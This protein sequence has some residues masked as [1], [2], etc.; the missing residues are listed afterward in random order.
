M[1]EQSPQLKPAA[2]RY[3]DTCLRYASD[4]NSKP[5]FILA[6]EPHFIID[7]KQIV[8]S[9]V[10]QIGCQLEDASNRLQNDIDVVKA[11]LTNTPQAYRFASER[12]KNDKD[13][14]MQAVGLKGMN[15]QHSSESL[16]D[17][18]DLALLAV[19]KNAYAL[20]HVSQRLQGDKVVVL[21]AVEYFPEVI[22][23]A[24]DNLQQ[25]VGDG[26]PSEIIQKAIDSEKLHSKLNK[27]CTPKHE[28]HTRKLKI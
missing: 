23:Y 4:K 13:L 9:A 12:L 24:S 1:E 15:I 17:D 18:K 5:D 26:N 20:Q 16:R 28:S 11:A 2:Q 3:L 25:L 27:S 21:K 6:G 19:E 10:S 14:A 22:K 8:I 7:N